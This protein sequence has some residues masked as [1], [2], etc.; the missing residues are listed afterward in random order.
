[1]G[2]NDH[3][4]FM[5]TECQDCGEVDI[6]EYWDEVAKVR[7]GGENRHLGE[8]LGHDDNNSGRCPHCGS[9][10]GTIVDD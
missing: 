8:M 2:W 3:V 4:E 6:W 5:E 1:V 10:K 9:T 7:Y